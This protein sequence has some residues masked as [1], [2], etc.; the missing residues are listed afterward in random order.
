[1][2]QHEELTET[3]NTPVYICDPH[4]P[5]QRGTNENTNGLIRDY[6]PKGT[7]FT[8]LTDHDIHTTHTEL[9]NHTRKILGCHTPA[10]TPNK[11]LVAHTT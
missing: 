3:T 9:N 6:Y 1:M 10:A 11:Q 8:T 7:D 4:S 5:W 2:A